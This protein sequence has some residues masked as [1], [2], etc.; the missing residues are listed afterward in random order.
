M[1]DPI[2]PWLEKIPVNSYSCP[3]Y[4]FDN[5]KLTSR[6]TEEDRRTRILHLFRGRRIF[7]ISNTPDSGSGF[8]EELQWKVSRRIGYGPLVWVQDSA[9]VTRFPVEN[10]KETARELLRMLFHYY[11]RE[12]V[13]A[14]DL[15]LFMKENFPRLAKRGID[16]IL[17]RKLFP[18]RPNSGSSTKAWE[19]QL[20]R[21]LN[22][23]RR[24]VSV[25]DPSDVINDYGL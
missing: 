12:S 15:E 6:P 22:R 10:R 25:R 14:E 7:I 8:C 5:G 24:I 4:T 1:F 9:I 18:I 11:V 13:T 20:A 2:L 19:Q 21:S 16:A 23:T 17:D 3:Q